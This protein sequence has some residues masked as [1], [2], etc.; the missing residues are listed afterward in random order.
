MTVFCLALMLSC[1]VAPLIAED[2]AAEEIS[3]PS[4]EIGGFSQADMSPFLDIDGWTSWV[5]AGAVLDDVETYINAYAALPKVYA[6]AAGVAIDN[7]A[8]MFGFGGT[9]AN[10]YSGNTEAY[11]AAI[12]AQVTNAM[13]NVKFNMD[14]ELQYGAMINDLISSRVHWEAK[15]LFEYQK[16]NGITY[17]F[18]YDQIIFDSGVYRDALLHVQN[19]ANHYKANLAILDKIGETFI[20]DYAG[21]NLRFASFGGAA[22]TVISNNT[23]PNNYFVPTYEVSKGNYWYGGQNEFWLWP[24]WRSGAQSITILNAADELVLTIEGNFSGYAAQKVTIDL[25]LGKYKFGDTGYLIPFGLVLPTMVSGATLTPCLMVLDQHTGLVNA[26][27]KGS[28]T[29]MSVS[30]N[31]AVNNNW[32]ISS[33]GTSW[34][35]PSSIQFSMNGGSG[36]NPTFNLIGTTLGTGSNHNQLLQGMADLL[37]QSKTILTTAVGSAQAAFNTAITLGDWPAVLVSP[38][39][40]LPY[41]DRMA[42][43]T[44]GQWAIAYNAWLKAATEWADGDMDGIAFFASPEALDL[45]IRGNVYAPNGSITHEN[46]I[47]TPYVSKE[48]N[49]TKGQYNAL[50]GSSFLVAFGVTGQ[51]LSNATMENIRLIDVANGSSIYITEMERFGEQID[52]IHLSVVALQNLTMPDPEQI[53]PP[54]QSMDEWDLLVKYWY[55]VV[56]VF[57]IVLLLGGIVIKSPY[58]ILAGVI[59]AAMGALIALTD[60]NSILSY[61]TD[62]FMPDWWPW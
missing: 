3:E 55:Y 45:V 43:F 10:A 16:T 25:P 54:P 52:T 34:P 30:S 41:G 2:A 62:P 29:T 27:F 1:V 6:L 53:T 44:A 4:Y 26:I 39:D 35:N 20:G 33:A 59:L 37:A 5:A 13:N 50:L 57:G 42:N 17:N 21:L 22:Y 58:V 14:Q 7:L 12:A 28:Y 56:M 19:A 49:L 24:N 47:F 51:T 60:A 31:Y 46:I 15:A 9:A 61:L 23:M 18:D 8:K 32:V 38:S 48:T 40:V 36:A 11:K